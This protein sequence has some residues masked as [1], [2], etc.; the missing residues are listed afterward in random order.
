MG[1]LA[2][3]AQTKDVY[4]SPSSSDQ[5]FRDGCLY[6]RCAVCEYPLIGSG[7]GSVSLFLGPQDSL[8]VQVESLQLLDQ[9]ALFRCVLRALSVQSLDFSEI[10]PADTELERDKQVRL[11]LF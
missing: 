7:V 11:L 3:G 10:T 9:L 5:I 2:K 8:S 4:L 1:G 6:Y